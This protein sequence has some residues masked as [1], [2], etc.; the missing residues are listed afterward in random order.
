MPLDILTIG[1]AL[2]EIMRTDI[3]QP[4]DAPGPSPAPTP[5]A[6][7]HLR[8]ASRASRPMK[9]AAI[10]SV[11]ADA[12]GECLLNQ[13]RADG[14]S[15]LGVRQLPD[16][17]TGV[18]F[19]AYRADGSRSFVF[20]LGAGGH[21]KADMLRPELFDGLRCL[22]IMGSTLSM[23]AEVLERVSP[24]PGPGRGCRRADQLRPQPAA[25]AAAAGA[26]AHRLRRLHRRRGRPAA[27]R[28]RSWFSSVK[29]IP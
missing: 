15:T 25:G 23:S 18:A 26:G 1:E 24:S 4:L 10:G 13:L 12:F 29:L 8:R 14:V 16:Q 3:D 17:P 21:I 2:V 7:L 9:T 20:S 5:A 27:D 22:H 19:V 6:R 28:R 11:G